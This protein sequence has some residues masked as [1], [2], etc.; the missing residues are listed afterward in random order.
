M[1]Y[2]MMTQSLIESDKRKTNAKLGA[3]STQG[4][5]ELSREKELGYRMMYTLDFT[6]ATIE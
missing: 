1:I 4:I 2:E 5:L 3:E 6:K